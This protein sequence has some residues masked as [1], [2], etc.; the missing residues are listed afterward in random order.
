M[1]KITRNSGAAHMFGGRECPGWIRWLPSL[2]RREIFVLFYAG[3]IRHPEGV[4][5]ATSFDLMSSVPEGR[6]TH[7]FRWGICKGPI[8]PKFRRL[9]IGLRFVFGIARDKPSFK[10]TQRANVG[11]GASGTHGLSGIGYGGYPKLGTDAVIHAMP[12]SYLIRKSL[13]E[14]ATWGTSSSSN[15]SFII[16]VILM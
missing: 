16:H 12:S 3:G 9:G 11:Q 8:S 7:N 15:F 10:K 5:H 2:F 13:K 4:L 14:E 6:Y 1:P